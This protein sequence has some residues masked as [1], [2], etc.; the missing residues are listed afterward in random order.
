MKSSRQIRGLPPNLSNKLPLSYPPTRLPDGPK[1]HTRG[2]GVGSSTKEMCVEKGREGG[3]VCTGRMRGEGVS[4][5]CI[6]LSQPVRI[7]QVDKGGGGGGVGGGGGGGGG[8][9][10]E[11]ERE[12]EREH[13][14]EIKLVI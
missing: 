9:E 4:Y 14:V 13:G 1:L 10:R 12:R 6:T 5:W 3:E 7:S 8:G 2:L 11:R